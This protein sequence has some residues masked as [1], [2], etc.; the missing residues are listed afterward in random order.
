MNKRLLAFVSAGAFTLAG[1]AAAEDS[2]NFDLAAF[3]RIDIATGV[4]AEI[5][6]GGEQ[7]VHVET[8]KGDFEDLVV[9]VDDG[10]LVI[11]REWKRRFGIGRKKA[12][13]KL[14]AT[15]TDLNAVEASSGSSLTASGIE[16][17]DFDVDTSSGASV[18]LSGNC[19]TINADGSSGSS[20]SASNLICK[21]AI[22]DASSGASL[23]LHATESVDAEASSGAS[24]TIS[25]G[26]EKTRIS[27]S[28]G[29]SISVR[30]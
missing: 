21:D 13:Y 10:E 3:D 1:A 17:S 4:T 16:G 8:D 9:K 30:D 22:A 24:V 28:S 19:D 7:S 11:K 26:A 27:K 20:V 15:V 6:V 12:K 18:K 14:I 23:S 5:T 29:G 2:R 25:G